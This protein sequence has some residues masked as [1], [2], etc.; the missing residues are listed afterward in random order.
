M[1]N[2]QDPR[3]L[4]T[5]NWIKE[6]YLKLLANDHYQS[7]LIKE[8]TD[9]AQVNRATFYKHYRDKHQLLKGMVDDVFEQLFNDIR[10]CEAAF[11]F[12]KV[13]QSHPR[14]I[15]LLTSI[16][17][18]DVFFSI[19]LTKQNHPYFQSKFENMIHDSSLAILDIALTYNHEVKYSKQIT[20][21]FISTSI[22][23]MIRWWIEEEFP[24][25]PAVLAQHITDMI[26]HGIY[27]S[28]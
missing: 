15:Q 4:R 2:K 24:C 28:K 8:I 11:D 10:S 25:E 18:R 26:D 6:A 12:V 1:V 21:A 23:G 9:E 17:E 13:K 14:F 27:V 19:M 5:Q 3:V 22:I 20:R 16:R 7:I